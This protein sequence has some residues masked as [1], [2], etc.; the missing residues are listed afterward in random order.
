[1]L[2]NTL[3][4]KYF[5]ND[6]KSKGSSFHIQRKK[7]NAANAEKSLE[8][9]KEKQEQEVKEKNCLSGEECRK[10]TVLK[11]Q[12][13]LSKNSESLKDT[14]IRDISIQIE[15]IFFAENRFVGQRYKR[16]ALKALSALKVTF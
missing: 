6:N 9:H 1:M 14:R 3:M 15:A 12:K 4:L 5:P 13:Y 2:M 10:K 7:K 16:L 8:V 11:L